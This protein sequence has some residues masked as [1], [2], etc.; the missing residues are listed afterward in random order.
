MTLKEIWKWVGEC[1]AIWRRWQ[2]Q[3]G[4]K[5]NDCRGTCERC[6]VSS[7][8]SPRARETTYSLLS[9]ASRQAND[10]LQSLQSNGLDSRRREGRCASEAR[11][12]NRLSGPRPTVRWPEPGDAVDSE[13]SGNYSLPRYIH[14]RCECPLADSDPVAEAAIGCQ[15]FLQDQETSQGLAWAEG[16][17]TFPPASVLAL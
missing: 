2:A 11:A 3:Q 16:R 5:K 13:S 17:L 6:P 1:R 14:Q 7:P 4:Q 12:G 8:R 15:V 10:T 9:P